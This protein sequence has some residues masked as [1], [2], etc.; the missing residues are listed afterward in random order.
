MLAAASPDTIVPGTV[1]CAVV[2]TMGESVY[3]SGNVTA[4]AVGV[5]ATGVMLSVPHW[6]SSPLIP[7]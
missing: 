6:I 3:A 2:S 4:F 5:L 7:V 1:V